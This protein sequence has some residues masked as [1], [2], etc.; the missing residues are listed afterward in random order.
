MY[1]LNPDCPDRQAT[2][3]PGEYRRGVER[4]PYCG[5]PLADRAR[6]QEAGSP[7]GPAAFREEVV[8]TTRDLPLADIA[9]ASL[10]EAGIPYLRRTRGGALVAA[11]AAHLA[12]IPGEEHRVSVA[13]EDAGEARGLLEGIWQAAG[14]AEEGLDER[15]AVSPQPL[16]VEGAGG[17]GG[18]ILLL[19]AAAVFVLALVYV[20]RGF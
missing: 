12:P 6:A 14:E 8:F 16:T 13:E 4:C 3:R 2:G 5:Q 15:D 11:G 18:S 17:R 19:L 10:E 9:C 1:C 20:L 7:S